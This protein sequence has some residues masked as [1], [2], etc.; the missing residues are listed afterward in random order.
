MHIFHKW[1]NWS[2]IYIEVTDFFGFKSTVS[3]QRRYC[4]TC[5][6]K[7]VATR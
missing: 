6:K 2:D 7:K 3:G 4:I 5:G 1:G